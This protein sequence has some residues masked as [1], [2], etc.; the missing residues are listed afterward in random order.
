M[1]RPVVPWGGRSADAATSDTEPPTEWQSDA[2]NLRVY[3]A[4]GMSVIVAVCAAIQGAGA[5]R[6]DSVG[7]DRFY[8]ILAVLMLLTAAFGASLWWAGA[9]RSRVRYVEQAGRGGI[10]IGGRSLVFGLLLAMVGCGAFLSL[11]AAV[12][13]VLGNEGIP[14]VAIGL[15]LIAGICLTFLAEV[16]LGRIRAGS[17]IV[18]PDGIRLRGWFVESYLPW[19]SVRGIRAVHR[20][21]PEIW[22]EGHESAAWARRRTTRVFCFE[23]LP[24][25]PRIEL[26]SRRL[27]VEPALLYRFLKLYVEHPRHRRELGTP[28]AAERLTSGSSLAAPDE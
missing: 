23:R 27:A 9:R 2:R 3:A 16:A 28:A 7:A 19:V 12:E 25:Q 18:G 5:W 22:I 15:A 14:V 24:Q 26:D 11:G 13:I 8:S 21:F 1:R 4:L 17:L 20:G 6:T 10:E